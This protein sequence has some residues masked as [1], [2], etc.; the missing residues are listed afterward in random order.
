MEKFGGQTGTTCRGLS[1]DAAIALCL[2]PFGHAAGSVRIMKAHPLL[3]VAACLLASVTGRAAQDVAPLPPAATIQIKYDDHVRPILTKCFGC[4]GPTQQQSGLRL[5]LRQNALRGGD[6]GTVIVP[7]RSAES[8]LILRLT[9]AAAGMRMP[10]TEP[11]SDE[12]VGVLRAW[13]DQGAE[14]PGR[15]LE[16]AVAVRETEP[17][18]Q[19]F[20][21]TISRHDAAAVRRALAVDQ[22]LA[23]AADGQGST[24]LMH[25]AY[26]GTPEI[27]RALIDA[28]A[29]LKAANRRRATALHWAAHDPVKLRLLL[30]NGADVNARTV[31]G[32]TAL[33]TAA[34]QPRGAE[35]VRALVEVGADVNAK[36]ITG[37]TPLFMAVGANLVSARLLL[38]KGADPNARAETGVTPLMVTSTSGAVALLLSRGADP[39]IV[40]KKGETAI[41]HAADIGDL[42]GVELMLK[43]GVDVN[44]PDYRGYTPLMLAAHNDRGQQQI[45]TLL[46]QHGAD[47]RATGENETALSLAAKRGETELTRLLRNAQSSGP[48][49]SAPRQR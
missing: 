47:P 45:V 1:Q 49:T 7:G 19:A 6:Y 13:I 31:E 14:M 8:K 30:A 26:A 37:Q 2:L 10:P 38:D 12:E 35:L 20:I 46:L 39:H 29:D 4:H 48:A 21:E 27:M 40:A 23:R 25:A 36:T 41:A 9:G 18:V 33:H 16:A 15:A 44:V 34:I 32:R 43:R 17:K 22:S 3:T 24:T 5:D 42:E 11:L 28:G